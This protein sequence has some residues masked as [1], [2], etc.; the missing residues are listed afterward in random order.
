M[1]IEPGDVV[2]VDFPGISGLKR[3]PAVVISTEM[4]HHTRPDVI[5]GLLTSQTAKAAQPTDYT[6]QDWSS[7]GLRTSSAFRTFLATLPA[8]SVTLVGHLSPR[9]WQGVQS[10]LKKALAVS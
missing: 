1:M 2:T 5:L 7:A 4:Y 6:L 10:C 8:S 9:D 3:R